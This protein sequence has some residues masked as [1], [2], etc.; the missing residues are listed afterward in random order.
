[1]EIRVLRYFLEVARRGSITKAAEAVHVSQPSLSKQ[2][3][4]LEYEL[5]KKLFKRSNYSVKL[6]DEGLLLKRRAEDIL[7]MVSKTTSEFKALTDI[8]GGDIYIGCAESHLIGQLAQK[9]KVFKAAYP[10]LRYH[11]SSGGTEQVTERLNRGLLDFAIIVEPPDLARYNHIEI[12]GTDVWGLLMRRDCPLANKKTITV[13][14]LKGIDLICSEQSIKN[15]IPRWCGEKI[16]TLNFV[17]TV[18]LFYNGAVFVKEGVGCM[19]TFDKLAD[20]SDESGLCFRPLE[21]KL[22]NKMYFIWQKYQTFTPIA[23]KLIDYLKIP[24]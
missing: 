14:D 15:D 10:N 23:E 11:I 24:D 5:G 22:E 21:P 8:T 4:D 19:L 6:T 17:G 9:I 12:K 2:I 13:D 16:D 1:M 20:V 3:K 18:N 7:A